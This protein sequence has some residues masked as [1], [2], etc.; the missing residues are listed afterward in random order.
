M[1][2]RRQSPS[3]QIAFPIVTDSIVTTGRKALYKVASV[4]SEVVKITEKSNKKA[5][6]KTSK[7]VTKT[8]RS[9]T[10]RGT[11][12]LKQT[13]DSFKIIAKSGKSIFRDDIEMIK[14]DCP[15]LNQWTSSRVP[16]A[17]LNSAVLA[18]ASLGLLKNETDILRVT[19][20]MDSRDAVFQN[21]LRTFVSESEIKKIN[22]WMDKIPYKHYIGGGVTHRIK[23]G[24]DIGA[25]IKLIKNHNY[26][27]IAVWFNHVA[28]QDFWTPAGIPYL[29]S[30][31][32][33]VYGWIQKLGLSKKTAANLVSVNCARIAAILAFCQFCRSF[34]K[35]YKLV[36]KKRKAKELW[37]RAIE[38]E[39]LGD[40]SA[41]NYC[42]DEVLAYLPEEPE[43]LIWT[44]MKYFQCAQ[45]QD[46]V[47]MWKSN[48][49]RAYQLADT[50]RIKLTKDKAVNFGGILLSLR[51]LS[52]I[53]MA[54]SWAGLSAQDNYHVI[55]GI[56]S[57]GVNDFIK[58]AERLEKQRI[59]LRPFSIVAN[60]S[61][62]LDLLIDIPFDLPTVYTPLTI[63]RR[64]TDT[65]QTLAKRSDQEGK[66][67][68]RLLGSFMKKY[69]LHT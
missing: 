48:L 30:G 24:H 42:Y 59:G 52:M 47:D 58:M 11:K 23:H 10:I 34:Y 7:I 25:L 43:L 21:I 36:Q 6:G 53:I 50:V 15:L 4:A 41:A 49:L 1:K 35:F 54:S 40:Y 29:P 16:H 12:L 37:N 32:K 14:S 65:L 44:A 61:I 27:G 19:R 67:S 33:S 51:G 26:R 56:I 13:K 68:K 20:V 63:H 2:K 3:T 60:N 45:K 57:S 62:V 69:P 66:Y 17:V 8:L 39:R 55:R 5:R 31:S 18:S 38:L 46:S 22:K 28:L 64:I 9:A